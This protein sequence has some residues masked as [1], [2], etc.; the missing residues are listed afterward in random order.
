MRLRPNGKSEAQNFIK[1]EMPNRDIDAHFCF[2]SLYV[3]RIVI[4]EEA[5]APTA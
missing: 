2:W 4:S 1:V 3:L 5:R